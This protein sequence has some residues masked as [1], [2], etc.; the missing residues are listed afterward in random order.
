MSQ[1]KTIHVFWDHLSG[2]NPPEPFG[3]LYA[4]QSR[5]KEVFSFALNRRWLDN[6][7]GQHLDPDLQLYAGQQ[8]SSKGSFGLFL[9]SSPDRWGRKL[10]LRREAIQA[11]KTQTR[12]RTL[13]ESDYLLGVYDET[14]MGALRFKL[15]PDGVFMNNDHQMA[16]PPWTQL[17]ELEEASRHL[18][19]EASASE[20]EKWLAALVAPGSS[21]GGARPKASVLAPN[22]ELWIA[23]FPRRNDEWDTPA[24]EYATMRMARDAGLNVPDIRLE[25]FSSAGST[26]LSRRFD[27]RDGQRVHFA[28]AMTMLAKEDG[29]SAD[30]GTSYLELAEW[31]IQHGA[32]PCEDLRELWRRIVFSIAISNTDDHLRNH[33]FLLEQDGWHLSP[34]YDLN[35]NPL[36]TGLALNITERDNRLDFSLAYEVAPF[37]RIDPKEASASVVRI[38]AVVRNW[39]GYARQARISNASQEEMGPAFARAAD[40]I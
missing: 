34:V 22:G 3:V 5:G 31:I 18:E 11:A 32:S 14:R 20:H 9:D 10:M 12:P 24:W 39:R 19:D 13:Q 40:E 26:F 16:A 7:P 2:G 37:F 15:T 4:Q 28:S 1:L 6:H 33:G 30:D 38:C 23:K 8:F 17:R 21:L 36:G 35:P 27:R 25:L 29:T